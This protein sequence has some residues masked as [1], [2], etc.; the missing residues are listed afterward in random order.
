MVK[1]D[2]PYQ[3]VVKQNMRD[4]WDSS[5]QNIFI[6]V[7]TGGGKTHI[8]TSFT[9]EHG[10]PTVC[11]AHRDKLIAQASCDF[12]AKGI[13]HNIIGN[14]DTIRNI[15]TLHHK[16][17]GAS[18]YDR[19]AY[20]HVASVDTLVKHTSA[21]WMKRIRYLIQDE[22]HHC[23]RD[24]KWGAVS[25]LFPQARGLYPTATPLRADGYGLSRATDGIGDLLIEGP[26]EWELMR[27]GYLSPYRM[28]CP[29]N[30]LDL[31]NISL[32]PTGDFSPEKLR[33]AVHASTITGN[34]VQHY[35]NFTPGQLGLTFAVDIQSCIEICEEY[36]R[37][38]VRA[39]IITSKTDILI[40]YETMRRF[41]DREVLMLV[42]VDILGEG[43]D[44]PAVEV[45][46]MARPTYSL[47]TY[48]QQAG[49]QWRPHANKIKGTIVDAVGNVIRHDVPHAPRIW[50]LDRRI[51]KSKGDTM[52]EVQ[53][54]ICLNPICMAPYPKYKTQCPECGTRPIPAA[55]S[56]IEQVEGDLVELD[57]N[58]LSKLRGEVKRIEGPCHPPSNLNAAAQIAINRHHLHRQEI[59]TSLRNVI[60]L[61]A[62]YWKQC[63]DSDQEIYKRFY[64][65]YNIDVLSAQALNPKEATTLFD[66]INTHLTNLKIVVDKPAQY[67]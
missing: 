21:A 19:N 26:S 47:V 58:A 14:R 49:R 37:A 43:T 35:L 20:S 22:G 52:N 16:Q 7:P 56:S 53:I 33:K 54:K 4:G 39:E 15:I 18:F 17:F 5:H 25:R 59:Q 57:F 41:E 62:G 45:V 2:R 12:A 11:V 67:G 46:I 8:F 13:R 24:N 42:S 3:G 64:F 36:N 31:S 29:E 60:A 65:S 23:L 38:G 30:D 32:T 34:V 44:I 66:K 9:A 51:K 1:L 63:G 27:L 55:R 10:E 50:T 40:R 61:Q 48:R 28:I 6:R